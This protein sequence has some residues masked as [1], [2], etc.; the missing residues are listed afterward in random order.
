MIYDKFKLQPYAPG[1]QYNYEY[2]KTLRGCLKLAERERQRVIAQRDRN[3]TLSG[4][5]PVPQSRIWGKDP[6]DRYEQWILLG[7][8]DTHGRWNPDVITLGRYE[9]RIEE[10]EEQIAKLYETSKLVA[11]AQGVGEDEYND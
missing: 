1:H 7:V 4:H 2:R 6:T 10:L 11:S 3:P 5:Y 8:V 9:K